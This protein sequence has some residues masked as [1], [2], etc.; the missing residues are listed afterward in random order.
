MQ[1]LP[2]LAG[3][4]LPGCWAV[5][6]PRTV[7]GYV[8]GSLSVKCTYRAGQEMKP[9]FW[10]QPGAFY[11]CSSD[12]VITSSQH[13]AVQRG[14]FSIRD[15]RTRREFTVTMEG[16]AKG[17]AGTYICGV[18]TGVLEFDKGHSVKV[19]VNPG[20]DAAVAGATFTHSLCPGL[21]STPGS[22]TPITGVQHPALCALS[23]PLIRSC[24]PC[25][26]F[27]CIIL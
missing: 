3:V 13:P 5:T 10:C 20:C 9:K 14:R 26:C 18:R 16:L 22:A 6:D 23:S 8:G 17:D 7:R 24:H 4:L 12:I 27:P 1:L 25:M 2:L 21:T 11:T 19:I 15:N